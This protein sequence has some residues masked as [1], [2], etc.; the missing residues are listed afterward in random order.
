MKLNVL[1][2]PSLEKLI[3]FKIAV[4]PKILGININAKTISCYCT[5]D[6]AELA[7]YVYDAGV[8]E[9]QPSLS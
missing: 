7:S 4:D 2:F 9:M 8:F 3:K 5:D 1:V 6:E